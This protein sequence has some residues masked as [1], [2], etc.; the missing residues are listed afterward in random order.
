MITQ[1]NRVGCGSNAM[2]E[3]QSASCAAENANEATAEATTAHDEVKSPAVA[4]QASVD[5]AKFDA[6]AEAAEAYTVAGSARSTVATAAEDV[7]SAD[8]EAKFVGALS[9]NTSTVKA[10]A[11]RVKAE[12]ETNAD[13]AAIK[14]NTGF[15]FG[16]KPSG[17]PTTVGGKGFI[18]ETESTPSSNQV[19]YWASTKADGAKAV[20]FAFKPASPLNAI[21]EATAPN[22]EFKSSQARVD[23]AR[24]Y[25]EDTAEALVADAAKALSVKVDT[26]SAEVKSSATAD[27]KFEIDGASGA[28]DEVALEVVSAEVEFNSVGTVVDEASAAA[29]C[30]D[31]SAAAAAAAICAVDG[32]AVVGDVAVVDGVAV[33]GAVVFGAFGPVVQF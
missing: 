18:A 5:E 25:A 2:T 19:A 22:G 16:G 31:C 3:E 17:I 21:A 4:A 11:T 30:C 27:V 28:D 20:E 23:E 7:T 6:E 32:V 12:F 9:V 14:L 10:R 24:H 29:A 33:V 8:P 15:Y 13:G 26:A 1:A